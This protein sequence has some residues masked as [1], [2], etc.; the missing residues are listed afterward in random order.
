MSHRKKEEPETSEKGPESD[1]QSESRTEYEAL[2]AKADE[3]AAELAEFKDKYLRALADGENARKRIRQQCDESIKIQRED[4]LRDLLTIIDNLERAVDAARGGGNG[5]SIVEGVEMV[6]NSMKDF[7]R[8]HGVSE[9]STVGRPFD[10]LL[11]EAVDHVASAEHEPNTVI[12]EF[13]RGYKVGD[14]LLRPAR[15]SVAKAVPEG[16]ETK[17]PDDQDEL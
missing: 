10:P 4:L 5:K 13:N 8:S 11:H 6:L 7:L 1:I 3:T 15:V 16:Q 2:K 9:V 17:D 14:R 12:N